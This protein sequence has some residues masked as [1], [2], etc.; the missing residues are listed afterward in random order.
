LFAENWKPGY[1]IINGQMQS[2]FSVFSVFFPAAIGILAGANISGDLRVTNAFPANQSFA[3]LMSFAIIPGSQ[4]RHSKRYHFGH[5][6]NE[7][8]LRHRCYNLRWND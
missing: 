5:H 3:L 8:L 2:F 7:H 4:Q 6:H 1:A